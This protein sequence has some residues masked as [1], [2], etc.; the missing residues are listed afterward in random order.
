MGMSVICREYLGAFDMTRKQALLKA[1]NILSQ[2]DSNNQ[3]I[4]KLEEIIDEYPSFTWTDKSILDSI[5]N[6]AI[7]NNGIL[8]HSK[9]LTTKNRLPSN[10]VIINKFGFTSICDFFD[11]YFPTFQRKE[12]YINSTYRSKG[13]DYYLKTF[14]DNYTRIQTLLD[15]K[16]V[17]TKTYNQYKE[18]NTPHS[19]TIIKNCDCKTWNELLI[20]CGFKKNTNP[21]QVSF[22][23]NYNDTDVQNTNLLEILNTLKK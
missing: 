5:E 2:D 10:T 6:Y 16:D 7:E 4:E 21:L 18:H 22:N 1:I 12:K 15:I 9:E 17:D 23:V 13:E 20:L 14:K 3:I 11:T 8:P 19:Y